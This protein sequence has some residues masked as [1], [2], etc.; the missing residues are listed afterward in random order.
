ME[1]FTQAF[2][3]N[4]DLGQLL[5]RIQLIVSSPLS[6]CLQTSNYIFENFDKDLNQLCG[7]SVSRFVLPLCTERVFTVSEVGQYRHNLESIFTN[8][9]FDF[10]EP[11]KPWWYMEA[12]GVDHRLLH[13]VMSDNHLITSNP[14]REASSDR[15]F[16]NT[17]DVKTD[18]DAQDFSAVNH[19]P[20]VDNCH[21]ITQF[22]KGNENEINFS[23]QPTDSY[24]EWRPLG[25]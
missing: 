11:Y 10:I 8:W 19:S 25:M 23:W 17:C 20:S 2:Q 4:S 3:S 24:V 12:N 15:T 7:R 14:T 22:S 18:R 5:R 21:Q 1:E 6:R 16:N 9:D 13:A